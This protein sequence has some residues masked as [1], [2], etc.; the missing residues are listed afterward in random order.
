MHGAQ[1]A[2][3]VGLPSHP[4]MNPQPIAANPNYRQYATALLALVQL[5]AA[6]PQHPTVEEGQHAAQEAQ[7][8]DPGGPS[9]HPAQNLQYSTAPTN[10]WQPK[11]AFPKLRQ[12]FAARPQH[13]AVMQGQHAV[14]E[15]QHAIPVDPPGQSSSS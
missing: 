4:E 6:S 7:H 13:P 12:H 10:H 1:H 14:M 15:A 5:P 8:A 2:A 9:D 3:P 11:T